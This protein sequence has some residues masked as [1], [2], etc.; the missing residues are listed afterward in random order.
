MF[1]DDEPGVL[2]FYNIKLRSQREQWTPKSIVSKIERNDEGFGLN[3][4]G[5][6]NKDIDI[7]DEY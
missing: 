4:G 2:L 3:I 5:I 7:I 6:D 1:C